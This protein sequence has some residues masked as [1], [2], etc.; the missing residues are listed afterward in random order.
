MTPLLPTFFCPDCWAVVSE[1]ATQCPACGTDLQEL[2]AQP[3]AAKLARALWSPEA[4]TS[5]RAAAILGRRRDPVTVP[6]LLQ[7][8]RAGADPYLAAE[9]AVAL[10]VIGTDGARSALRAMLR[11]PSVVVR[12]A[13]AHAL[14]SE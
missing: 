7:R 12:R 6:L 4:A 9:I 14:G 8:Y 11:D 13:A 5:R 1:R 3:Y 2:D 10:G